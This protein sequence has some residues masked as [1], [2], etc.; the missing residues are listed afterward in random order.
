MSPKPNND[1]K[2]QKRKRGPSSSPS[3]ESRDVSDSHSPPLLP[4][5]SRRV[6][7][8]KL[9]TVRVKPKRAS[10]KHG[11]SPRNVN[12]CPP[13]SPQMVYRPRPPFDPR[14]SPRFQRN[15]QQSASRS[16][17]EFD[18]NLSH[19]TC[20]P[21]PYEQIV[22]RSPRQFDPRYSNRYPPPF[23]QTVNHPTHT[24][25]PRTGIS[26]NT[27]VY[28]QTA[29]YSNQPF[30]THTSDIYPPGHGREFSPS[31]PASTYSPPTPSP[32]YTP[33]PPDLSPP[34]S[35][36]VFNHSTARFEPV[37]SSTFRLPSIQETMNN[38]SPRFDPR[39]RSVVN[40]PTREQM[41]NSASEP[42]ETAISD[43]S[44]ERRRGRLPLPG[45][46]TRKLV[47]HMF[48]LHC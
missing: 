43:T 5:I 27:P 28:Q 19:S 41:L 7:P 37:Y 26:R 2:P 10:G 40:P 9:T 25:D 39:T 15:L 1:N 20:D 29:N 44:P 4:P 12:P 31:P 33:H 46:I 11:R 35:H 14:I 22:N 36:Q 48:P 45:Y 18:P 32:A 42:L 3:E 17:Y 47:L 38:P 6:Q 16:T 23:Q 30:V 13:M 21:P 34:I 24:F 8:S